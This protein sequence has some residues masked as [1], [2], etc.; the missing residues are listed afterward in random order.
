M[1]QEIV[2]VPSVTSGHPLIA[3][4]VRRSKVREFFG[5]S[6]VLV[7][8]HSQ[9]LLSPEWSWRRAWIKPDEITWVSREQGGE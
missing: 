5:L 8:V 6:S 1:C 7:R 9:G 2:T 4:V 3:I